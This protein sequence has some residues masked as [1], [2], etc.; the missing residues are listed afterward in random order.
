MK[1]IHEPV[2]KRVFSIGVFGSVHM[3]TQVNANKQITKIAELMLF[4]SYDQEGYKN[5]G[6][7]VFE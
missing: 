5:K 7:C 1:N 6:Q 3:Q 2:A 4:K